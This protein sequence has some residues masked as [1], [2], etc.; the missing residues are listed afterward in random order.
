MLLLLVEKSLGKRGVVDGVDMTEA[1]AGSKSWRIRGGGAIY[2]GPLR[3]VFDAFSSPVVCIGLRVG[4]VFVAAIVP[5]GT[6][7][8]ILEGLRV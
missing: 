2:C 8:G 1:G 6:R 7:D 3:R 4:D 5:R